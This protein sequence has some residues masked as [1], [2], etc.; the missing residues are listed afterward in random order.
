LSASYIPSDVE[1]ILMPGAGL[2]PARRLPVR[3]FLRRLRRTLPF[4]RA[5][6]PLQRVRVQGQLYPFI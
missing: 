5:V 1:V 3:G 2:E 6:R 4:D